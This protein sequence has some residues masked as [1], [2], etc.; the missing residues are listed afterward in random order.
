MYTS[1]PEPR[2][3]VF[4]EYENCSPPANVPGYIVTEQIRKA[5]HAFGSVAVFKAYLELSG[6]SITK[7]TINLR[8]EL[9]SS[10]VSLTDCPRMD[11]Q[12]EVVD[13]MILVDMM[14]FAL[15]SPAPAVIMLISGTREFGYALSILRHRRYTVV[16]V[17]PP[18]GSH[19]TLTSQANVVLDWKYDILANETD[20]SEIVSPSPSPV[21]GRRPSINSGDESS[22]QDHLGENHAARSTGLN[23]S[24][25]IMADMA[26]DE[27]TPASPTGVRDDIVR[28]A[29]SLDIDPR[30]FYSTKQPPSTLEHCT[31]E[32][33]NESLDT[34][35][36]DVASTTD[37]GTPSA[38]SIQDAI[39]AS[40]H[41]A[42]PVQSPPS[43][44]KPTMEDLP[45]KCEITT[46]PF[47]INPYAHLTSSLP[48]DST[49]LSMTALAKNPSREFNDLLVILERL[50][51]IGHEYP[52]WT[53]V[54]AELRKKDPSLY[55]RVGVR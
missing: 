1:T 13:K 42:V 49:A 2:V 41:D 34:D 43:I 3:G 26:V 50:R 48:V 53:L 17:T 36:S 25:L 9:Q 12:K 14:A 35:E 32:A 46:H 55:R 23:C 10:G 31:G 38:P 51:L 24:P 47:T 29:T 27:E 7:E 22:E 40:P 44:P 15:D 39:L 30:S 16:V 4:W 54:G 6:V 45:L 52:R 18:E 20:P 33:Q 8:S 5:A 28:S 19:I 11:R 37:E 21:E